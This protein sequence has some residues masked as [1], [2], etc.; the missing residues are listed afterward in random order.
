MF[1]KLGRNVSPSVFAEDY[2]RTLEII[3]SNH[4]NARV[5]LVNI[6]DRDIYLKPRAIEFNRI[7]DTAAECAGESFFVANLFESRLQ[8]DFYYMNTLD[9]LHPDED[10]MRIIADVIEAA[11][12]KKYT[13]N[14][15]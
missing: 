3:K 7:I 9:G 15:A 4:S 12:V 5:C 6:P 13:A 8:G 11:I 10:G 1:F 14:K 2:E